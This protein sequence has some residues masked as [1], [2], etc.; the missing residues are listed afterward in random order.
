MDRLDSFFTDLRDGFLKPFLDKEVIPYYPLYSLALQIHYFQVSTIWFVGVGKNRIL[1]ELFSSFLQ[2]AGIASRHE[3][4]E[5]FMHGGFSSLQQK[6]VL[7]CLSKSGETQEFIPFLSH[8]KTTPVTFKVLWTMNSN[9]SLK[10]NFDSVLIFKEPDYYLEEYLPLNSISI[11]YLGFFIFSS[12]LM[13]NIQTTPLHIVSS[14]PG[15][16][17]LNASCDAYKFYTPFF[18]AIEEEK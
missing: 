3:S 14:H 9:P 15:G 18:P 12:S 13:R 10:E 17:F 2:T 16:K 5:Y 8:L 6:D 1:A 4:I 7:I 11:F